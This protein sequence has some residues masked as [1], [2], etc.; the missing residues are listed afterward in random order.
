MASVA[1]PIE[2]W[3]IIYFPFVC[4]QFSKLTEDGA[5]TNSSSH[6]NEATPTNTPTPPNITSADNKN[7]P[8]ETEAFVDLPTSHYQNIQYSNVKGNPFL[9][10]ATESALPVDLDGETEG[11][12]LG[13]RETE[14]PSPRDVSV[15][16]GPV[17]EEGGEGGNLRFLYPESKE[18]IELPSQLS[19]ILEE[20]NEDDQE[21]EENE[22]ENEAGDGDG[23]VVDGRGNPVAWYNSSSQQTESSQGDGDGSLPWYQEYT[24]SQDAWKTTPA[25][26][27]EEVWPVVED[28]EAQT[29]FLS[30]QATI[31]KVVVT[32]D[33]VPQLQ[34]RDHFFL[35][36]GGG[37]KIQK[38]ISSI[39]Y[40]NFVS[41]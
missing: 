40:I 38:P 7:N 13:E 39:K 23:G 4:V 11:D 31:Q 27:S 1:V 36:G 30:P 9:P 3:W 10:V 26:R 5:A 15:G 24:N 20:R 41:K 18:A 29:K 19:V 17:T 33:T 2:I 21:G 37:V 25:Y 35:G 34:V 8:F 6:S 22:E 28:N 14:T 12:I 16:E 32:E